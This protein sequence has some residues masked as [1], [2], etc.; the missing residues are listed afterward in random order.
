MC[1]CKHWI[2]AKPF[3]IRQGHYLINE[4]HAGYYLCNPLFDIPLDDALDLA[5]QFVRDLRAA[6]THEAAH[7]AHDVLPAL[8]PCIGRV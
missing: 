2:R 7:N 3:T 6:A 5:S 8:W 1:T 4:H